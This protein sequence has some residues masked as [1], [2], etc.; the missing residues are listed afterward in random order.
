[1][2]VLHDSRLRTFCNYRL[3]VLIEQR[4]AK[5]GRADPNGNT[6]PSIALG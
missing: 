6:F 4:L 1:M 3:A 5:N 2:A